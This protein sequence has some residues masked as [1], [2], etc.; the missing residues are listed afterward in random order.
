MSFINVIFPLQRSGK[1]I[2]FDS[3]TNEEVSK[4][5]K[6]NLKNIILTAP[7]EKLWDISFGV[8]IRRMIFENISSNIL[9]QYRDIILGQIET[10]APYVQVIN[11]DLYQ[12]SD[13][14]VKIDLQYSINKTNI[15][16]I[17]EIE[18]NGDLIW[19]FI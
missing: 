3:Y 8:G 18:I 19:L 10:Y 6:F 9:E 14:G 4:A 13:N 2:G 7:G 17:L 15:D 1:N 12:I 11:I 5:V 16:D